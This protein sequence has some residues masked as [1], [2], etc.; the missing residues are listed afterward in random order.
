MWGASARGLRS[1]TFVTFFESM[2]ELL[3]SFGRVSMLSWSSIQV[4]TQR[5]LRGKWIIAVLMVVLLL[6]N[7]LGIEEGELTVAVLGEVVDFTIVGET[8]TGI[9]PGTQFL[10]KESASAVA[11]KVTGQESVQ[12]VT[13]PSDATRVE[14]LAIYSGTVWNLNLAAGPS[15]GLVVL[16]SEEAADQDEM[17]AHGAATRDAQKHV[18]GDMIDLGSECDLAAEECYR[19]LLADQRNERDQDLENARSPDRGWWRNPGIV[20]FRC[21]RILKGHHPGNRFLGNVDGHH[22]ENVLGLCKV[23]VEDPDQRMTA[24]D[25]SQR[26]VAD[27]PSWD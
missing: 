10:G 12:T 6:L 15:L 25:Q 14:K 22:Q 11:G 23:T 13:D 8:H 18:Q 2:E 27:H 5:M 4:V 9:D 3:M 17:T 1:Q 24:D 20:C 19:N 16:S 21:L 26:N 7:M